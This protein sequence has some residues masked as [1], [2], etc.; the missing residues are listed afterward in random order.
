MYGTATSV[1]WVSCHH[2]MAHP[3]VAWRVAA[4]IVNKTV[5]VQYKTWSPVGQ[6]LTVSHCKKLACYE[7]LHRTFWHDFIIYLAQE[8]V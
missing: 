7:L 6:G 1:K 5:T 3:Q 4:G 2:S 8:R